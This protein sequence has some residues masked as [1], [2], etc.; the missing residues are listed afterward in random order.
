MCRTIS[1][2]AMMIILISSPT[3]MSSTYAMESST[4][5]E[6][7]IFMLEDGSE[8]IV[9]NGLIVVITPDIVDATNAA[10]IIVAPGGILDGVGDFIFDTT[11]GNGFRCTGSLLQD[12][13]HVLTAA[14]CL[15]DNAGAQD[16]IDGSGTVTFEGDLGDEAID[17]DWV[18]IHP[19]FDGSTRNGNDIAVLELVS[20]ASADITRYDIDTN[21]ADDIGQIFSL[22]G[23][24]RSGTG[25]TG[26]IIPSGTKR[27]GDNQHDIGGNQY[28]MLFGLVPGVDFTSNSQLPYDFDNG[29]AANDAFDVFFTVADLGE[30]NEVDQANGDSGGPSFNAAGEIT[31]VHSYSSSV[32]FNDGTGSDLDNVDNNDTFGEF[33][34]D[35]RVSTYA[36]FINDVLFTKAEING[37]KFDDTNGDGVKDGG[38][39][40]IDDWDM[41]LDCENGHTDSTT[42]DS[43]GNY[44]FDNIPAFDPTSC[45]VTEETKA[46]WTPTTPATAPDSAPIAIPGGVVINGVDFGNFKDVTIMGEKWEDTDADGIDNANAEPRLADWEITL[47]HES[48]LELTTTTADGLGID[49]LGKYTFGPLGP[50]WA[51]SAQICETVKVGWIPSHPGTN[52]IDITIESGVDLGAALPDDATDFGNLLAFTA[53]KTWTET[54]YNWDPFCDADFDGIPDV[55]CESVDRQRQI[56]LPQDDVLADTLDQ[57]GADKYLVHGNVHPKNDKFQN[58]Q[59]GAFYALTTVEVL[60]DIDGLTVEEFYT[61]CT[62][63]GNGILKLLS[64]AAKPERAVKVAIADPLPLDLVTEKTDDLSDNIGGSITADIDSAL[65]Q[66]TEPIPAGSKVYVLVKFQDN[67]KGEVFAGGAVDVMCDNSEDVDAFLLGQTA[68][69]TVDAS[70]RITNQVP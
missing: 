30:D 14:H 66:I 56:S 10:S 36:D 45:T 53:E 35:A 21:A 42:T 61:D 43:N 11:A 70:L 22:A 58:T 19:D 40:G 55:P 54:D 41:D 4:H 68:S 44:K 6:V 27:A 13:R 64:P 1:I 50:E 23:Y 28:L 57:D 5:D 20:E 17:V 26:D 33:S 7:R 51:G 32:R 63:G 16:Y 34:V 31:G 3:L 8:I 65:V 25:T 15:S 69:A 67:L 29:L 52:C 47:T 2:I 12:G 59:P 48:G 18:F 49:P 46:G 38:E 9:G 24:G 37:M 39:P 60:A 62:M